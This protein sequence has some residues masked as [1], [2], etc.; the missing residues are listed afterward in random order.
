[1]SEDTGSRPARIIHRRRIPESIKQAV[2][3]LYRPD[4]KDGLLIPEGTGFLIRY[5]SQARPD[6]TYSLMVTARHVVTD[7]RGNLHPGLRI[8]VNRRGGG[9]ELLELG[10]DLPSSVF[11][12]SDPTVDLCVL[13]GGLE[14]NEFEYR[15]L[16][17][18]FFPPEDA[19]RAPQL[20]EGLEVVFIGLFLPHP[21]ETRNQPIARFGRVALVPTEPVYWEK[22]FLDLIL[23]ETQSFGGNSGAPVFAFL[24]GSGNPSLLGVL[25]GSFSQR[26]VKIEEFWLESTN[27]VSAVVPAYLLQQMLREQ[28]IPTLDRRFHDG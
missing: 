5:P 27:G 3:V 1:M 18:E 12:H 7:D 22:T 9:V 8:R 24:E 2:T 14:R 25:K 13:P 23:I 6:G 4:P 15:E 10:D 20:G 11:F 19:L 21:G 16:S 17:P 28:V 26:A